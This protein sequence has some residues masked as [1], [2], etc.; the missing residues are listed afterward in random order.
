MLH[1]LTTCFDIKIDL[2]LKKNNKFMKQKK[3]FSL[4]ELSIV[5]VIAA[6]LIAAMMNGYS[7]WD[8][9]A[10]IERQKDTLSVVQSALLNYYQLNGRLPCPAPQNV[11]PSDANFGVAATTC[12]AHIACPSGLGCSSSTFTVAGDIPAKTLELPISQMSDLNGFKYRY[13]VDY[14]FANFVNANDIRKQCGGY[15]FIRVVD[16]A[17][18]P[19]SDEIIFSLVSLGNTGVGAFLK[20]TGAVGVSGGGTFATN[21]DS[22]NI[23]IYSLP[24]EQ[25]AAVTDI[26]DDVLAYSVNPNRTGCPGGVGGCTI[27]F[28]GADECTYTLDASNRIASWAT[29]GT[30][31]TQGTFLTQSNGTQSPTVVT[32]ATSTVNGNRYFN[33][34]SGS[35]QYVSGSLSSYGFPAASSDQSYTVVFRTNSTSAS[36]FFTIN[37]NNGTTNVGTPFVGMGLNAAGNV[38]SVIDG[39]SVT[40]ATAFN[41]NRIHVATVIWQGSSPTMTLFVDGIQVASTAAVTP[42][43]TT[44]SQPALVIGGNTNAPWG[45][46][47]GAIFEVVAVNQALNAQQR[48]KLESALANKWAIAY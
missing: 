47:N 22:D 35:N 5:L 30:I 40:S 48:I 12:N 15:G 20:E 8:K 33:F 7:K 36:A 26:Y 38:I 42:W 3:A 43:S 27:W 21:Y 23:L 17:N 1:F 31:V 2:D 9:K 19:V 39:D 45:M 18:N 11:T 25:G 37:N 29:K 16:S 13:L 44:I 41:D 10:Q 46:F 6:A 14:R 4:V 34:I 32:S 24:I 28:D